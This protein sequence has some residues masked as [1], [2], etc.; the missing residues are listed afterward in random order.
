MVM[1]TDNLW[2]LAGVI[3]LGQF[4]PGPDMLLLTRTALREG[5]K[6]GAEMVFGIAS[7]LA[8]HATIAVVGM[9]VAFERF[10]MLRL[11]LQWVAAVYLIW[12]AQGLIRGAFSRWKIG[13]GTADRL[14][15]SSRRAFVRGLLCNLFNPKVALFL[16]A[17]CAPFLAGEHERWWPFAIWGL[18]VGLGL[19]LW[20]LWVVLLQWRPLR[21]GYDQATGW[22]DGTFGVTLLVLAVRLMIGW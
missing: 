12:L 6:A 9:A 1:A 11:V 15:T 22:I 17:V 10:P 2:V 8:I 14:K 21:L 3:V 4:S 20:L 16:S 13:R 7:G 19:V 18:V 5:P